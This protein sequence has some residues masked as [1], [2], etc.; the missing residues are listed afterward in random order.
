MRVLVAIVAYNEEKSIGPVIDSL[1]ALDRPYDLVV[2]DNASRD[3]TVRICNDK[4]VPVVS[5]CINTGGFHGTVPTYFRYAYRNDY[6]IL[7]QFDGD[8]QHVAA[9][10]HKIVAPVERGEADFVI[11]SRF[12]DGEG[13]QS[14]FLRRIGIRLFSWLST[15]ITGTRIT[16][17]TSGFRAYSRKT[18]RF[19]ASRHHHEI[20]DPTQM[21]LL[22]HFHGARLAEVPVLMRDREHGVSEFASP[23]KVLAFPLRGVINV[24]GCIL[25]RKMVSGE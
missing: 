16:D 10:L 6:D 14:Y 18:I 24:I 12:L 21:I 17:S 9:E 25:Q 11:G 2:I 3:G 1:L 13:F 19:F 4:G 20:H 15:R 5:H 23:F 22:S 8:G 7:C